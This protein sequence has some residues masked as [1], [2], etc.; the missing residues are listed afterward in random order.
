[1]AD[2][3]EHLEL[4]VWEVRGAAVREV[5]LG[6]LAALDLLGLFGVLEEVIQIHL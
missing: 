1:M 2:L 4:Q 5:V 3:V 6:E